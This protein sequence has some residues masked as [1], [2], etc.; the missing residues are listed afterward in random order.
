MKPSFKFSK[1]FYIRAFWTIIALPFIALIIIFSLISFEAFGPMPTFEDLENPDNN[2][3]SQVFSE[4][5]KLL[6]KYYYQN[7]SYVEFKEL[8]PNIVNA[9][10]ATEDI[11]F[12]Q[13]SGIDPRGLARV[14]FKT[15]LLG[16]SS[17]GGSTITQQLA[18]NL[19]PR[20]TTIYNSQIA[21]TGNLVINKFKEWVTA[22]KLEKNYTKKEILVMYLNTVPF[23]GQ[24][25]GIKSAAKT[26]F[27]TYPDSLSIVEA[28]TLVGVLKAPTRYSPILH[29]ERCKQRRNI[30]LGQMNKY[31]FIS[32]QAFDSLSIHPL[33]IEYNIQDHNRGPATYFREHLRTLLTKKKPKRDSY[34][35]YRSY[36]QDSTEWA[37]NPLYG[38]CNKNKKPNGKSY[39]LY[40]DGL[41]IY[42]TI[43]STMQQYAEKAV[44]EHLSEDLQKAFFNEKEDAET[45]PFSKELSDKQVENIIKRSI[46]RT[47]RYYALNRKGLE[48]DSIRAVFN[49]PVKMRVFSWDGMKDTVMSPLDSI[50]YYKHFLR[51]GFMSMNPRNGHVKA[52]VG[53]PNFKFFKYDHVTQGKRQV[54]STIK[55]FLYTLA[56]QEGYSPC[57]PVPN[58][59][60]TFYINDTTWTPKNSGPSEKD[61]EMVTLK[62][63]LTNSVNWIS[64]WLIKRFNPQSVIDVM[65]KLGIESQVQPVPSIFLGTAEISLYEMVGAYSTYAN[66]GVY[67]E[68]QFI[69]RIEDKNGN[70]I[71]TFTPK[72]REALSEQTSYL[73][74]NLLQGVV[75]QGTGI[76]LRYKY[77][78]ESEIAGKTG[79]TQ[80]QSDGW[81]M[82]VTPNLVSGVWVGGE[83]RSIHFDG[84]K[85]GQG[86]NMA[87]PIWALYMKKIYA[88]KK[89]K[90]IV[91]PEDEFE[92]PLNFDY[93]LDCDK[94][95]KINQN[96]RKSKEEDF[97]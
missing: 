59:P 76:R 92:K 19:F 54:G 29:P 2:L 83:N 48:N 9:L 11:R 35:T 62:W 78:F 79:T 84:I 82:G 57:R 21:Y 12:H 87:L 20:D 5:D 22:V 1:K 65:H 71:S 89:L 38:W 33:D 16:K 31:N 26:F 36:N 49:K 55:P 39:N 23:G 90:N 14:A 97:F 6:G 61:G 58:V 68:P 50:L 46:R 13:H 63:G 40:R 32:D 75:N 30:V 28:A 8:S 45:A 88:D 70:V 24:S 47:H 34:I 66:K 73:M 27:N 3:A 96:Q 15:V 51:A 18:K 77:N 72:K 91:S 94:Y 4:D 17:G 86:A 41:R 42:T 74:I 25:Y 56:M 69:S 85:L 93:I 43:N 95:E 53:G 81:F 67:I 44:R 64:A 7:R 60:S 52:Y 37:N 10:L 80:N